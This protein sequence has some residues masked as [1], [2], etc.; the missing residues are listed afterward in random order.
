MTGKIEGGDMKKTAGILFLLLIL[1]MVI[2]GCGP[3]ETVVAN[4]G[5]AE[6]SLFTPDGRLF[7]TGHHIW[8]IK[9]NA[10]G[11]A[12]ICLTEN[13]DCEYTGVAHYNN[14]L[15]AVCAM[16]GQ[17]DAW[18]VRAELADIPHFEKIYPLT[19]MTLANGM[20]ADEA[21]HLYIADTTTF[22]PS[23]KIVRLSLTDD[24]VPQVIDGSDTVWLSPEEGAQSP[25]GMEVVGNYLFFSNM[26]TRKAFNIKTGI[27]RVAIQGDRPGAVETVFERTALRNSSLLD[28]F[29]SVNISGTQ[30]LIAADYLRGTVFTVEAFASNQ[31]TPLYETEEDKFAG[32]TSCIVGQG[33]GFDTQDLLV[34]E[35]GIVVID[36]NSGFGNRLSLVSYQP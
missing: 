18:L 29:T 9:Q 19:G 10:Q 13:L 32:P 16:D 8:E 24:P 25:N 3:R 2:A 23:G 30:Y 20:A 11:H 5:N 27:K 34:T 1:A 35:G 21:G 28:D 17:N 31:T 7:I 36:P 14:H 12:A 4:L 6:N 26:D 22:T 15:F 33:L